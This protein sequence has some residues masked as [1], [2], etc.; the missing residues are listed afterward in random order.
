M[1][2]SYTLPIEL[3]LQ[4]F[5]WATLDPWTRALYATDYRPFEAIDVNIGTAESR[6]TKRS[7][8]VAPKCWDVFAHDLAQSHGITLSTEKRHM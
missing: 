4:I 6:Y 8:A 3:W 5:R 2:P 1:P 7:L